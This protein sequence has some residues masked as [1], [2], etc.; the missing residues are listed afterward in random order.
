MFNISQ[1]NPLNNLIIN[2]SVSIALFDREMNYLAT[3]QRWLD[4]YHLDRTV[5]GIGG[6]FIFTEDITKRKQAEELIKKKQPF[7][8]NY[9]RFNSRPSSRYTAADQIKKSV[10]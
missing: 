3:T 6:I 8:P 7:L 5:L 1:K 9:T 2:A 4:D 10:L